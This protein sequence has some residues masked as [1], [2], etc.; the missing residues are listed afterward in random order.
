MH[1]KNVQL[2]IS[3]TTSKTGMK[4]NDLWS[5]ETFNELINGVVVSHDSCENHLLHRSDHAKGR[6]E[7][8]DTNTRTRGSPRAKTRLIIWHAWQKWKFS[9]QTPTLEAQVKF[10]AHFWNNEMNLFKGESCIHSLSL[11]QP[12]IMTKF[13]T[14]KLIQAALAKRSRR[15]TSWLTSTT[16]RK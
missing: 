15:W 11:S 6:D 9:A 13:Y 1:D 2:K 8:S 3:T 5:S 16:T 4:M 14:G 7:L 10:R 12:G